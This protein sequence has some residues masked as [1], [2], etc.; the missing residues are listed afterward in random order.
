MTGIRH[1]IGLLVAAISVFTACGPQSQSRPNQTRIVGGT[2]VARTDTIF[3]QV[4]EL[5][6]QKGDQWFSCTGTLIAPDVIVTA[7]HCMQGQSNPLVLATVAN[8]SKRSKAVAIHPRFNQSALYDTVVLRPAFDIALVKLSLPF[9][10]DFEPALLPTE[11][12]HGGAAIR[13]AGFGEDERKNIG[14]LKSANTIVSVNRVSTHDIVSRVGSVTTGF[15]DSGGPAFVCK[16]NSTC[17]VVGVISRTINVRR[18]DVYTA[19]YDMKSWI[20]STIQAWQTKPF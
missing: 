20:D 15:G 8:K 4:A 3:K 6:V 5:S 10:D 2:P 1:K 7:A 17:E 16:S 11:A 18:E 13:I 14:T 19:V 12:T 9:P